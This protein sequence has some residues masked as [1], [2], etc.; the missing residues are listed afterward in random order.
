MLARFGSVPSLLHEFVEVLTEDPDVLKGIRV[1]VKLPH[2]FRQGDEVVETLLSLGNPENHSPFRHVLQKG[3]QDFRLH[4]QPRSD[5]RYGFRQAGHRRG[6]FS[7]PRGK[8]AGQNL[9]F[10]PGFRRRE[11]DGQFVQMLGQTGIDVFHI[12]T[13]ICFRKTDPPWPAG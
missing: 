11:R 8:P 10:D 13:S 4:S 6:N 2:A 1:H 7:L 5:G 12:L 9:L 3:S